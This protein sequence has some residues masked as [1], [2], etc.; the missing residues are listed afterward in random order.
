MIEALR[1]PV[2]S[3]LDAAYLARPERFVRKAPQPP[4]LPGT[5]WINKPEDKVG[6]AQ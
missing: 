4:K 3:A 1:G 5:V 2:E 6:P